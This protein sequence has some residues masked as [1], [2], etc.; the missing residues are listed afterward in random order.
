[1]CSF[2][3]IPNPSISTVKTT[4]ICPIPTHTVEFPLHIN[5]TY[6]YY[7]ISSLPTQTVESLPYLCT[8]LNKHT[9]ESLQYS[10]NILSNLFHIYGGKH[11]ILWNLFF[12]HTD[13]RISTIYKGINTTYW[14]ESLLYSRRLL[15]LFHTSGDKHNIL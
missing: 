6:E 5:I 13:C 4:G 14:I 2:I 9:V 10:H 7:G 15:N 3:C 12:T 8:G 11:N 1:M